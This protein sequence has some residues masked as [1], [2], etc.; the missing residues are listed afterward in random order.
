NRIKPSEQI[1]VRLAPSDD[2]T[3]KILG[4]NKMVIMALARVGE[5]EIG[6]EGSLTKCATAP[7]IVGS[8]QVKVIVP[9]EGLVN[10][11]EEVQRLNKNIEKLEKERTGLTRRLENKNFVENAP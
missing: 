2:R 3:Q 9:L 8:S 5:C 6:E 11:D 4:N 10:F 7:V 1:K